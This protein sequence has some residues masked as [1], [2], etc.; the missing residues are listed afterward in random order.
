MA[1]Q[2]IPTLIQGNARKKLMTVALMRGMLISMLSIIMLFLFLGKE[3]F[4][5]VFFTIGTVFP[6]MTLTG[7]KREHTDGC[8]YTENK[9]FH[10]REVH[11]LS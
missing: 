6:V 7:N 1:G 10:S 9:L 3:V 11:S 2:L 5:P 8:K 4:S